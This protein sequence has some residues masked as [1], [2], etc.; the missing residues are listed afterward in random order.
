MKKMGTAILSA[1]VVAALAVAGVHA[2]AECESPST[3]PQTGANSEAVTP[4]SD[5]QRKIVNYVA[6]RIVQTGSIEFT[7]EE[8]AR[9]TGVP[10][11][12]I[13]AMD[14]AALRSAVL[15]ELTSRNFNVEAL[16]GAGNCARFSA[17]SIDSDL[18]GASGEELARYEAEKAADGMTFS[19]KP[20][21]EFSLPAT[22]GETVSLGDYRGK[23]VALILL[24]GH[25]NH[26][27][28]TIHLVP[29]LRRQFVP[30]GLVILP[31]YVNSGSVEDV[32]AWSAS[33]DLG[34]PV[35]VDEN[36]ALALAY[37]FRMVPTTFLIDETGSIT[38]KLV[39][40]KSL[41]ELRAA[42]EALTGTGKAVA[43]R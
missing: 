8:I 43:S 27:L 41:E 30:A 36:G 29:E 16:V 26:S 6:G 28:Q 18:N 19:G 10:E 7:T 15:A 24:S 25:C 11:G 32:K 21:P 14:E 40:Q 1:A 20:A 42:I 33:L 35:L 23:E 31:V 9:A 38:R 34:I 39:G 17:C 3:L 37:D 12:E 2:G 5:A 22:D 13:E 4:L